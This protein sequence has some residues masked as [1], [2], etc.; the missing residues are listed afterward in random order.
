[1]A[2][3]AGIRQFTGETVDELKKVTWPDWSQLRNSTF[4]VLVF[5]M[6]ISAIIWFMDLGVR[7]ILG[8]ILNLFAR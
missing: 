2:S 6:I 4:I 3:I 7:G 1:M 8:L 5:V